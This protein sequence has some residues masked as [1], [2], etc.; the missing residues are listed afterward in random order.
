[1]I[2]EYY[3]WLTYN[4]ANIPITSLIIYTHICVNIGH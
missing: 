3:D 4:P 2:K 1:M